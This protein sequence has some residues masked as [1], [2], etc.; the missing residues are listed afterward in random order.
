MSSSWLSCYWCY[1]CNRFVRLYSTESIVCPY[2]FSGF[3]E[4]IDYGSQNFISES[5]HRWF[6]AAVTNMFG[7]SHRNSGPRLHRSRTGSDWSLFNPV[8]VLP[9]SSVGGGRD[10]RCRSGYEL[11]YDDGD[12][13]G[14]RPL[15]G[16][17]M[18]I[19]LGSAFGMVL[20]RLEQIEING[21]DRTESPP[22]S[23]AAIESI[24]TIKI[25][26]AHTNT[27]LHCAVCKEA[28][29][30]GSRARKMPCKHIFH[31]ECIQPWLS[32]RNSCP[33]CRHELPAV[34]RRRPDL[35][36]GLNG[37]ATVENEEEPVGLTIW[38]LPTG[39]FAVGRFSGSMRAADMNGGLNNQRGG[40]PGAQG[41]RSWR[42]GFFRWALR[43]I[44]PCFGWGTDQSSHSTSFSYSLNDPIVHTISGSHS[45]FNFVPRRPSAIYADNQKSRR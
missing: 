8:I 24:P 23:K 19:L 22:A 42:N 35:S 4:A 30:L 39:G 32:L 17:V 28:F 5:L 20:D 36:W 12:G 44:F 40:L 27:E 26:K 25:K 7:N 37:Q 18:E 41:G 16:N 38:R 10:G 11:Y 34:S 21:F 1:R 45:N 43:H 13:S 2:C 33:V 3:V 31:S 29:K 14:L 6:P 15:P 9:G